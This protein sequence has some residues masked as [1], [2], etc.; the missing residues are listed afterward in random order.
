MTDDAA[1]RADARRD[2]VQVVGAA[3][4][5][6]PSGP[7]VAEVARDAEAVTGADI[8]A[9]HKVKGRGSYIVIARCWGASKTILV[10]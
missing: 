1:R 8:A 5:A 6:G 7:I 3:R 9:A 4:R 2:E 10:K